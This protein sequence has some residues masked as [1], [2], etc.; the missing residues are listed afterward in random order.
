MQTQSSCEKQKGHKVFIVPLCDTITYPWTMVVKSLN[1]YISFYSMAAS[2]RTKDAAGSAV[3]HSDEMTTD[4]EIEVV[5]IIMI[6]KLN[7]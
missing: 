7:C 5:T 3:L 1:T 6:W 2:W 4:I